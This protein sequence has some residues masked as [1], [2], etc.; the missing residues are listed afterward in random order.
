MFPLLPVPS[1]QQSPCRAQSFPHIRHLA[2]ASLTPLPKQVARRSS[3]PLEGTLYDS[4]TFSNFLD[5]ERYKLTASLAK[6]IPSN[7]LSNLLDADLPARLTLSGKLG[8]L[9]FEGPVFSPVAKA[10]LNIRLLDLGAS[11]SRQKGYLR[12][13]AAIR[14][15]GKRD[16]GFEIDRKVQLFNMT[17]TTLYGNVLYKTTNKSD[18]EWK[19]T[20]SF[21]IH[22]DLK[23]AGVRFAARFGL[24]PEG[25]FVYDLKL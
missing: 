4:V 14:S 1:P 12:F 2:S 18:G 6:S 20:S 24:T 25:D 21:G 23:L 5:L 3:L 22:Q 10:A 19:T 16:H 17:A 11:D 15:N 8:T 9:W 13:K 7:I